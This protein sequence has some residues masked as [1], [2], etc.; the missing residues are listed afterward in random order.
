MLSVHRHPSVMLFLVS[1]G[2]KNRLWPLLPT[3][4]VPCHW[5]RCCMSR[6]CASLRLLFLRYA[7]KFSMLRVLCECDLLELQDNTTFIRTL[8]QYNFWNDFVSLWFYSSAFSCHS[9]FSQIF[10]EN[11]SVA[12]NIINLRCRLNSMGLLRIRIKVISITFLDFKSLKIYDLKS[13]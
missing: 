7:I 12:T 5:A 9:L 11:K 13:L 10:I 1:L 8:R 3:E 6:D 2:C 4:G